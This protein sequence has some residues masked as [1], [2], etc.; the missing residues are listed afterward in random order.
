MQSISVKSYADNLFDP[1]AGAGYLHIIYFSATHIST[2]VADPVNKQI[3]NLNI[4][5]APETDFLSMS[6]DDLKSIPG[7]KEELQ[8][9]YK[10]R[11]VV[12]CSPHQVLVPESLLNVVETEPYYKLSQKLLPNSQ[13]L[14]CKMHVQQTA[15]I[16]NVRNELMKLIRF[17]MPMVDVFHSS[18]LFI[19]A[20]EAQGFEQ[21]GSKLHVQVHPGFLEVLNFDRG[22]RFYNQFA[23]SSETEMVYFLLASA[24]HLDISHGCDVVLYGNSTHLPELSGLLTKY[25]RS[26]QYGIKPKNFMYP[27]S[28]R[29]FPEHQFFLESAA[30]LCE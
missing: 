6:Y 16:F 3:L 12:I 15:S 27:L 30:L 23:C 25:V 10:D 26:V 9:K 22:I 24:E 8:L 4:Y 11:R 5:T 20:I 13:V 2:V 21:S 18:L 19:K 14:Y 28:F 17:N 7:L 1:H 29:Q